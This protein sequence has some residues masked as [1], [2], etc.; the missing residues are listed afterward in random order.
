MDIRVANGAYRLG[1]CLGRGAFGEVFVGVDV[2]SGAQVAVKMEPKHVRHPQLANEYAVYKSLDGCEGV[3]RVHWLGQEGDYTVMVLDLLGPSL[4]DLAQRGGLSS[5]TVL[6]LGVQI[7]TRLEAL[8]ARRLIHRDIKPDNCLTGLG[9]LQNSVYLIDFGLAKPYWANGKHVPASTGHALTGSA[10]YASLNTHLGH[11]QSRRD[12]L[13]SLGYVLVYLLRG[14]LPWQG[15]QIEN[16]VQRNAQISKL[17]QTVPFKEL[18]R[19]C[20]S[21]FVEYFRYVRSLKYDE[22]P[23]YAYLQQLFLSALLR[24]KQVAD[25]VFEWSVVQSQGAE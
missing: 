6:M 10:R 14:S 4:E 12:D 17:K 7:L 24:R 23:N 9:P 8:H 3:P 16:K 1:R 5:K 2:Q 22:T 21:Q 11:E 20:P 15:L 25:N 19:G 18:C 13:E